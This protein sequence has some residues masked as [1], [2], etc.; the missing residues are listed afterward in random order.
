MPVGILEGPW[1]TDAVIRDVIRNSNR[2]N[3]NVIFDSNPQ[4]MIE[5]LIALVKEGKERME[6]GDANMVEELKAKV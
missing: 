3:P 2:T 5:R 1:A 6:M 4:R